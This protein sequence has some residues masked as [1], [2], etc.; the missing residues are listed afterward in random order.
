VDA[1]WL[2]TMGDLEEARAAVAG[3]RLACDLPLVVTL[4]FHQ[5][6]RTATGVG[7]AGA[8]KTLAG[9]GLVAIGANCGDGPASLEPVM[10]GMRDALQAAGSNIPLVAKANAGRPHREG[11]EWVYEGT[12]AVMATYARRMQEL[13]ARLIGACCGSTPEQVAAMAGVLRRG[14]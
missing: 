6:G 3:A 8:A 9:W 10:A 1:L 2:E 11:H 5:A 4:S 13:G 7:P 12:P 14:N